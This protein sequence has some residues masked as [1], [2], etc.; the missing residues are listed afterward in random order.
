L[1]VHSALVSSKH[2]QTV[3]INGEAMAT[4]AAGTLTAVVNL[5]LGENDID[6]LLRTV[7][8]QNYGEFLERIQRFWFCFFWLTSAVG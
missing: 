3:F 4:S 2:P 6:I 1:T 8:L 5:S 7:G